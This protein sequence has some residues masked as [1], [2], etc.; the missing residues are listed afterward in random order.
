MV[1][2]EHPMAGF[3]MTLNTKQRHDSAS[4]AEPLEKLIRIQAF[5]TSVRVCLDKLLT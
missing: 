2:Q 4:G 3:G 5:E 1:G